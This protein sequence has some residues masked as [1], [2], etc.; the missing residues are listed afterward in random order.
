MAASRSPANRNW[1]V[2]DTDRTEE[3]ADVLLETAAET[4]SEKAADAALEKMLPQ[5]K[6]I[7]KDDKASSKV[8]PHLTPLWFHP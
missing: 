6:M 1:S 7:A 2:V 3:N 8:V 4:S 5:M